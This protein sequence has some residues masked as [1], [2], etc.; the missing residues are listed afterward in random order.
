[1]HVQKADPAQVA[2][3]MCTLCW[4]L[5]AKLY[6]CAWVCRSSTMQ[7]PVSLGRCG[8]QRPHLTSAVT[9]LTIGHQAQPE[10]PDTEVG[11]KLDF[12]MPY[13]LEFM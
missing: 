3:R 11:Q 10:M 13:F 5:A 1:M 9:Q 12:I 2:P 4:P 6:H 8:A 7:L